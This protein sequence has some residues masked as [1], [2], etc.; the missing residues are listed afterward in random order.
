MTTITITFSTATT[1]RV[2]DGICNRFNYPPLLEN[3]SPNSESKSQFAKRKV[4][5]FVK[6]SI[7]EAELQTAEGVARATVNAS[8]ESDIILT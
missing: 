8:I 1:N 7:R 5:E 2:I 6:N 3:G 4:L